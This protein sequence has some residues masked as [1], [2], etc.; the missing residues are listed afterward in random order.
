MKPELTR[1]HV[2]ELFVRDSFHSAAG[3]SATDIPTDTS[4]RYNNVQQRSNAVHAL[5]DTLS[6]SILFGD[7][8]L[9]EPTGCLY[10]RFRTLYSLYNALQ[11]ESATRRYGDSRGAGSPGRHVYVHI[12]DTRSRTSPHH[13]RSGARD[14]VTPH[15]PLPL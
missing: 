4:I 1:S 11:C 10:S 2:A 9:T 6:L 7:L 8:L 5:I 12:H 3:C 15:T 13:R 14:C